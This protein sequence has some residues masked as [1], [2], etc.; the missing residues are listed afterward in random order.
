MIYAGLGRDGLGWW[1]S[2]LV[3]ERGWCSQGQLLRAAER[4]RDL[5]RMG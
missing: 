2:P 4:Y 5:Y 3:W 1:M